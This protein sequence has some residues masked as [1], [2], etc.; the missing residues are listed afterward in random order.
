MSAATVP[1][2]LFHSL[3]RRVTEGENLTRAEASS[4][5]TEIVEGRA[6][7]I[8]TAAL[9][10]AWKTRGE[11]AAEV[12][13][14]VSALRE[15]MIAVPGAPSGCVDTC[16]TGG[17]GVGTF[18][19]STAAAFVAA[20]AGVPVAKHG[21]RAVSSVS[22][23]ADVLAALG[24]PLD[25]PPFRA[26][27]VLAEV[28]IVFLFAQAHHPALAAAAPVR[29]ALRLRTIFNIAGPLSNPAGVRRQV[30]GVYR[31][32][33]IAVVASALVELGAERAF[34]V[35]GDAD[36]AGLDEIATTG[37]T[38]VA[39]VADGMVRLFVL[40][41][42]DLGL[43]RAKLGEV[44]GAGPDANAQQIRRIL[45]G[46]EG[47]PRD[48]VLANAAAAIVVGG[49]A[50]DLPAGIAAARLSIDSGRALG[51]LDRLVEVTR[52]IAQESR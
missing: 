33:L 17:D 5:V 27:E 2:E 23:S 34:V 13:G 8:A 6:G 18:N 48:L 26:A 11:T 32:E 37:P 42:E 4:A 46:E 28:G 44:A 50:H 16:G 15:K 14:V 35:H 41:P 40:T 36:G 21:N 12:A 39:E 45:S 1:S 30:V 22:G 7:E 20:G 49:K 31:R 29:R 43:R 52:G 38:E 51:V 3:L 10:A 9:L 47:A 24:L 25:L 19:V